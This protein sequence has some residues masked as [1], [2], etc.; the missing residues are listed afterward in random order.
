MTTELLWAGIAGLRWP[1][2]AAA[3]CCAKLSCWWIAVHH[4][5][6]WIDEFFHQNLMNFWW[7]FDEIFVKIH[8][9]SS[10]FIKFHQNSSKFIKIHQILM[11]FHQN[12]LTKWR[13]EKKC[14]FSSKFWQ[15]CRNL[16]DFRIWSGA[17]ACKSG[18]SR[19][20]LQNVT[21]LAIVA[22]H[23]A[24]NEPPNVRQVMN[25]DE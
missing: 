21:L 24:E 4:P 22:V 7:I 18:R 3:A 15:E 6:W 10:K 9:N 1:R 11:K 13:N 17:K 20:M 5:K 12:Q 25:S 23:T 16:L 19:K 8:Q 14:K 2:N